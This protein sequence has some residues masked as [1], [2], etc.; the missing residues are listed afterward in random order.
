MIFET[1]AHYDDEAFH[2]D[3]ETLLSG[4]QEKGIGTVI[5][6]AADLESCKTTLALSKQYPFVYGALGVH[7]SGVGELNDSLL[8]GLE[9][10]CRKTAVKNGGKT[11]AVGEIGLDYY[12]DEPERC[13]QKEWFEKQIE[14]GKRLG[15][16]LIIHSRDAAKDTLDI[17]K[18]CQAGETGGI[19][20]CY[21]YSPE[22]AKA[23]LEMGYHFGIGGVITFQNAKKLKEV[24]AYLPIERIVLET[25][26][27]YLAPVPNRGKRNTSLNL[28]FVAEEI[29]KI[30]GM[31]TEEVIQ[32]TAD[33]AS[34]LFG[35]GQ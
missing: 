18:S 29:A 35:I 5:N 23:F 8:A 17:M 30:K 3:R 28:P 14:M 27:P 16:P 15:L 7:P 13:L 11:V 6:I 12:W 33:N 20:H 9:E 21:A 19:I 34:R 25:D 10:E 22:T 31:R 24:T 2:E 32:I 4:M 26:S 1:H